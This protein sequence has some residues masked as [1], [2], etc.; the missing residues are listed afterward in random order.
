M[1]PGVGHGLRSYIVLACC[2]PVACRSLAH[3]SG[4]R[5]VGLWVC[6]VACLGGLL[7]CAVV[8]CVWGALR[9]FIKTRNAKARV[10]KGFPCV[11]A[12]VLVWRNLSAYKRAMMGCALGL[13]SSS[14][15]AC[16]GALC[17]ACVCSA[18]LCMVCGVRC[19][20]CDPCAIGGGY[21]R[22]CLI[23]SRGASI[24]SFSIV[25]VLSYIIQLALSPEQPAPPL[26]DFL[27]KY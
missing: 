22:R 1:T 21:L 26:I 20:L 8:G 7:W 2:L 23:A 17:V 11:A 13:C 14:G 10:C 3:R 24:R 18:W 4:G 6:S 27:Y 12:A 5:S 19:A 15:C 16:C 9:L 25:S